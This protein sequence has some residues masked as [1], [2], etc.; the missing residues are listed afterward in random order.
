M[1]EEKKKLELTDVDRS[2]FQK[3]LKEESGRVS[4]AIQSPRLHDDPILHPI[5]PILVQPEVFMILSQTQLR[6]I[7]R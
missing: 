5:E 3:C 2:P 6:V 4:N 1:E 7:D